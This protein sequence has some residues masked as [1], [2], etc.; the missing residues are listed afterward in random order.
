M[1]QQFGDWYFDVKDVVAVEVMERSVYVHFNTQ[2]FSELKGKVK[3]DFM[4]AYLNQDTEE[5]G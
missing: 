3:K 2:Y 4:D 1:I 5:T